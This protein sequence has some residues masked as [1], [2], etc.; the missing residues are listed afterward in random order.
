MDVGNPTGVKVYSEPDPQWIGLLCRPSRAW[1][2]VTPVIQPANELTATEWNR[3]RAA[4]KAPDEN[5]KIITAIEKRLEKRR[6]ELIT[7]SIYQ[8]IGTDGARV[9][10][11]EVIRGGPIAGVHVPTQYRVAGYLS[12]TPRLHLRIVFDRPLRGP[13][14][15]GRGRHV[16]FGLMW[17]DGH[18]RG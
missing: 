6:I 16:G 10:S 13:L 3:L 8:A 15:L 2:S 12:E 9:A 11:V 5:A 4:R 17:P 1:V 14:A 7:R 18:D